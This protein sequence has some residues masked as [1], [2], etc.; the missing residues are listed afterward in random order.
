MMTDEDHMEMLA[1]RIAGRVEAQ[2]KEYIAGQSSRCHRAF[3]GGLPFFQS[4][5]RNGTP[6]LKA[7]MDTQA[8]Y[9]RIIGFLSAATF[10]AVAGAIAAKLIG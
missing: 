5:H 9:L 8:G 7:R 6:G 2:L 4:V 10:I 3:Y 1:E